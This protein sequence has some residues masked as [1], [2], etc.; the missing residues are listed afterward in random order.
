MFNLILILF[1]SFWMA[2]GDSVAA[3]GPG[4][5]RDSKAAADRLWQLRDAV[6]ASDDAELNQAKKLR[7]F[8]R[9]NGFRI[10]DF[11]PY[12]DRYQESPYETVHEFIYDHYFDALSAYFATYKQFTQLKLEKIAKNQR[13]LRHRMEFKISGSY[14][15]RH[16]PKNSLFVT[17]DYKDPDGEAEFWF[18]LNK[19]KILAQKG[20]A[21]PTWENLKTREADYLG[22]ILLAPPTFVA[23]DK[24]EV[25]QIT[26]AIYQRIE[27][28]LEFVRSRKWGHLTLAFNGRTLIVADLVRVQEGENPVVY[29]EGEALTLDFLKWEHQ[30][31]VSPD[32]SQKGLRKTLARLRKVKVGLAK[33]FVALK[34]LLNRK[35]L[36]RSPIKVENKK[37][38][39]LSLMSALKL[40]RAKP[41]DEV[42]ERSLMEIIEREKNTIGPISLPTSDEVINTYLEYLFKTDVAVWRYD[43]EDILKNIDLA[44]F[45]VNSAINLIKE[46]LEPEHSPANIP[47]PRLLLTHEDYDEYFNPQE[48]DKYSWILT[49]AGESH[50]TPHNLAKAL[51]LLRRLQIQLGLSQDPSYQRLVLGIWNLDLNDGR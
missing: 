43:A 33:D 21:L 8:L 28:F 12:I 4:D 6:Y 38:R 48:V 29:L 15:K 34:S 46:K 14:Q 25:G 44:L 51:D 26:P 23:I 37:A 50:I 10:R 11:A 22:A 36:P 49:E 9:T 35:V 42:I 7:E 30:R 27:K 20:I 40:V 3:C 31:S 1:A 45:A 39:I 13:V 18:F 32:R 47:Q 17:P 2:T 16:L 5:F 24:L 41:L 19:M